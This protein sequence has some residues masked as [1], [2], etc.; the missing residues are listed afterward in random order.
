MS[1]ILSSRIDPDRIETMQTMVFA[2]NQALGRTKDDIANDDTEL[3][4]QLERSVFDVV[5]KIE[6]QELKLQLLSTDLLVAQMH[7]MT[8]ASNLSIAIKLLEACRDPVQDGEPFSKAL[9]TLSHYGESTDRT[10]E[11]VFS[12]ADFDEAL[13]LAINEYFMA[14]TIEV[15]QR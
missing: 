7:N 6:N 10:G 14:L 1:K 13:K 5:D 4:I 15:L 3:L 2:A 8:L 11:I 12:A 9:Q